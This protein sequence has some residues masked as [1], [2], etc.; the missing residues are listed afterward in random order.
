MTLTVDSSEGKAFLSVADTGSGIVASDLPH[1]FDRF[2]QGE[3]HGR[4][5]GLG[6]GLTFCKEALQAM[7]GDI[8]VK[9]KPGKGSVFTISLPRAGSGVIGNGR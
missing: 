6:L 8:S 7:R 9:S 4:R 5:K 3:G 1:I 2:Y